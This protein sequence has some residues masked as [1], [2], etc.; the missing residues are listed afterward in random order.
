[1]DPEDVAQSVTVCRVCKWDEYYNAGK[2]SLD[3]ETPPGAGHGRGA[4]DPNPTPLEVLQLTETIKEKLAAMPEGKRRV[5]QMGLLGHDDATIAR[6]VGR[7]AS[8]VRQ[9]RED[10]TRQ[11]LGLEED[12]TRPRSA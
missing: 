5:I 4:A 1:V 9:V 7:T 11:L 3:R 2:R 12:D 10:F 8:R 6:S